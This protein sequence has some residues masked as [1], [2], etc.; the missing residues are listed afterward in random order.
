M[1]GV[2][3]NSGISPLFD[4]WITDEWLS[5]ARGSRFL[6]VAARL[7]VACLLIFLLFLPPA[8][9]WLQALLRHL[10]GRIAFGLSCALVA[11]T[12]IILVNGMR[13]YWKRLD[14]SSKTTKKLWFW[15]L[16]LGVNIG[17]CAYCFLVY[18]PQQRSS[19]A[20]SD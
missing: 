18:W 8:R 2:T 14:D 7:H 9:P 3:N 16:T 20:I 5:S 4:G 10:G 1:A 11:L 6:L 19:E 12:G 13:K 17:A 15:I